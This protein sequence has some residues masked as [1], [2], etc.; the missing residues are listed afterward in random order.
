MLLHV[1][2]LDMHVQNLEQARSE[3]CATARS[4]RLPAVSTA[5]GR[6]M[7]QPLCFPA[8]GLSLLSQE[9]ARQPVRAQ[10]EE[11]G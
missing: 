11:Q 5:V 9:S 6:L 10:R 2:K 4:P 8:S 1:L 3:L 7:L